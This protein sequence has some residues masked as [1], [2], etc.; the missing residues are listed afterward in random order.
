MQ[1]YV[2]LTLDL[3]V[4]PTISFNLWMPRPEHDKFVLV[5]NFNNYHLIVGI[6]LRLLSFVELK[7]KPQLFISLL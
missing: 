2:M 6:V 7:E 5:I 1:Q 4:I 3:N